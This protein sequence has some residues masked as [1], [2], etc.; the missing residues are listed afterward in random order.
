MHLFALSGKCS[1]GKTYIARNQ[2]YSL[3][4]CHN[5]K[6]IFILNFADHL[7][8]EL[9]TKFN[10][11]FDELETKSKT[12]TRELLQSYAIEQKQLYGEDVFIR[13]TDYKIK[14][15]IKN[16]GDNICIIIADLRF[17]NEYEYIKNNG[18]YIIRVETKNKIQ[19]QHF[20]ETELD[21][22]KFDII[23]MNEQIE[24]KVF[25]RLNT[26]IKNII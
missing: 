17:K 2:L 24:N 6:N 25:N 11:D 21:D 8:A 1:S 9:Y 18:G 16:Y 7:K 13:Y 12:E 14:S 20:S 23:V 19:N 22:S 4:E 3:L 10:I 5:I 26:F 15:L